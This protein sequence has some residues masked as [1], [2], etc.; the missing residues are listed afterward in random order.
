MAFRLSSGES[1]SSSSD[2]EEVEVKNDEAERAAK[3]RFRVEL[4]FVQLLAS[5]LY[6]HHLAQHDYF[7][8]PGFVRYLRYL[9]YWCR[10]EYARFLEYPDCLFYLVK[11]SDDTFRANLK[12]VEF[13][14]K[15]HQDQ[16]KRWVDRYGQLHTALSKLPADGTPDRRHFLSF[17]GHPPPPDFYEMYPE[18]DRAD[19]EASWP[20][21][22]PLN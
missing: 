14:D 16:Y 8:K 12:S 3:L 6:L 13:R 10:P 19:V 21:V 9:R 11:L 18:I 2:D 4:E 7:D 22:P 1:S 15:V 20:L 17:N 5:P